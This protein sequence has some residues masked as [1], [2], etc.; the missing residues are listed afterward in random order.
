M[1]SPASQPQPLPSPARAF[2]KRSAQ[3]RRREGVSDRRPNGSRRPAA[4]CAAQE[5]G[6]A[7]PG[8]HG[9]AKPPSRFPSNSMKNKTFCTSLRRSVRARRNRIGFTTNTRSPADALGTEYE[10]DITAMMEDLLANPTFG[11]TLRTIAGGNT[12]QMARSTYSGP[13]SVTGPRLTVVTGS[14]TTTYTP[15]FEW[16]FFNGGPADGSQPAAGYPG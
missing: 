2:R 5:R 14:G 16:D 7:S 12:M 1:G 3:R 13:V 10:F 6:P 15:D 11:I 4:R 9:I 8:T